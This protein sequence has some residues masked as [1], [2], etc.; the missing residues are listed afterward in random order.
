MREPCAGVAPEFHV[1]PVRRRLPAWLRRPSMPGGRQVRVEAQLARSRLH[2][3]CREARCPN[4]SECFGRGTATF[5]ILGPVCMRHC[6]FCGVA[7]G[8]PAAVDPGEPERVA[9]AAAGLGLGYV[10]VTSVTRD[11]LPDG[12]AG[13]FAAV[14]QAVRRA[15]PS[16]GIEVLVPD[17]R[18]DRRALESVLAAGPDVLNHNVETVPRL[19]PQV[20]PEA[21]FERSI[22]LLRAAADVMPLGRVKSGMMVGCGERPGEVEDVLGR[23]AAA[24]CGIVTIGQYLQPG[25]G[26]MEVAEFVPPERFEA[27]AATA[28]RLGIAQAVAGPY[29]RS[30]YRAAE[31]LDRGH[32]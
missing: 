13:Q 17:F 3:V 27:Y 4:R 24:G 7:Q 8:V 18:G 21:D 1:P 25:D 5:L 6:R 26:Q 30:S 2:T 9:S 15:L 14:I 29:V 16:A 22:A 32:E 20:R 11:D 28:R 10:V 12:G 19:Y 31:C 23:L